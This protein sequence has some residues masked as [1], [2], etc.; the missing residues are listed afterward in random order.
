MKKIH[1][2]SKYEVSEDGKVV[3]YNIKGIKE[4]VPNISRGYLRVGIYNDN[5]IRKS[6]YVHRLVGLTYIPLVE[7][8][9]CINHIDGNKFNNNY[10]NLEWVTPLENS[11]HAAKNGLYDIRYGKR[12]HSSRTV[13]NI[14]TGIFYDTISDAAKT[15]N[16]DR[17]SLRR[18]MNANVNKTP[19]IYV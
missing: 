14:Q 1:G 18:R 4:I 9:E 17:K 8:K 13:L 19:F 5:G 10:K 6:M 7:G 15:I 11:T 3:S 16:E 12:N 2:F